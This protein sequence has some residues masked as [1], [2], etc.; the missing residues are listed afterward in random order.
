MAAASTSDR[1]GFTVFLSVAAHGILVFG[2]GFGA[3]EST[4][5]EPTLDVT[6]AAHESEFA[7][8]RADFLAQMNQLGS[9]DLADD[10]S[11]AAPS[12]PFQADVDAPDIVP[13][14]PLAPAQAAAQ[15]PQQNELITARESPRSSIDDTLT[16]SEDG[17]DAQS[18]PES[19]RLAIASLWAQLD[20]Q[21]QDYAKRPRRVVL[22]AAATQRSEDA[23]YLEGWR[24]RIEAIGNLNY[25]DAARRQ[26][27]YG[28]LRLV[29]SLLPNGTVQ[30]AEIL[31]SSGHPVL[32]QAALDIVALAS[33]YE[34]FPENLRRQAD[35]VEIIRTWRFHEGDAL[36][37][38]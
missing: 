30:R 3:P 29:V 22:T 7:P 19:N 5:V 34:P 31:E 38:F 28:S 15:R 11:A 35:I 9:G 18:Q 37:S 24:R 14:Q 27:L 26:K 32:D 1:F 4:G 23:L 17:Q 13:A 12:S 16:L 21:I 36:R 25:P 20:S 6:L 8:E 33:P 2:I 10:A